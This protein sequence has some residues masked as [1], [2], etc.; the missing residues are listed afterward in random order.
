MLLD[1]YSVAGEPVPRLP[2]HLRG[3]RAAAQRRGAPRGGGGGAVPARVAPPAA[4]RQPRAPAAAARRPAAHGAQRGRA[5]THCQCDGFRV[6][7]ITFILASI[8]TIA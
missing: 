1:V 7:F 8:V 3:R 2:V 4:P 5:D 6:L